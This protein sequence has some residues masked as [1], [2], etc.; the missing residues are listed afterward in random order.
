MQLILILAIITF[1]M[2]GVVSLGYFIT[3]VKELIN[4]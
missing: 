3:F 2:S 4:K 1:I